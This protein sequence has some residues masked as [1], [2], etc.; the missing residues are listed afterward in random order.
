MAKVKRFNWRSLRGITIWGVYIDLLWALVF[1]AVI[2]LIVSWKLALVIMGALLFHEFGHAWGMKLYKVAIKGFYFIPFL[3]LVAV[4]AGKWTTR[5][6]ET[7][8]AILGPAWGLVSAVVVWILWK[9]TGSQLIAGIAYIICF[10]NLLNLMPINPLDGGRIVKSLGWSVSPGFGFLIQ[11]CGVLMTFLLI[12]RLS[13]IVIPLLVFAGLMDLLAELKQYRR[14]KDRKRIMKEMANFFTVELGKPIPHTP[15]GIARALTIYHETI[16]RMTPELEEKMIKDCE[17]KA[18]QI[19]EALEKAGVSFTTFCHQIPWALA[20]TF[21][22]RWWQ[23][24]K[25]K[26]VIREYELECSRWPAK[27]WPLINFLKEDDM[28]SMTFREGS[29]RFVA[30]LALINVLLYLFLTTGEVCDIFQFVD[31]L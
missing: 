5:R 12:G 3:G 31:L 11:V 23:P 22:R 29:W 6:A 26:E 18:P 9:I 7:D 16:G 2:S 19:R 17:K 8:I 15:E 14:I 10:I 28:P 20:T 21:R 27:N 30:Y 13:I 4:P 1:F 24:F 25:K